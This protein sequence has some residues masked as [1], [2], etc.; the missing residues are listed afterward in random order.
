VNEIYDSREDTLEHRKNVIKSFVKLAARTAKQ[1]SKHDQSKL[2]EPE[3]PYFDKLTPAL[4]DLTYGSP[5]YKKSL[6]L[7]GP[8]NDHH[9]AVNSH[10]PEHFD[11]GVDGMTLMDLIE[12]YCDWKAATLR[13]DDGDFRESLKINKKRFNLSDQLFNIFKNTANKLEW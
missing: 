9:R 6:N 5:E 4:K 13:H 11:N 12:M 1:V 2:E 10:H 8:A 7:L 3:K